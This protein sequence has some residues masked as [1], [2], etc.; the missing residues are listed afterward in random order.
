VK[1]LLRTCLHLQ[2]E[3]LRVEQTH[4]TR[5]VTVQ[6][7]PTLAQE[8]PEIYISTREVD[9]KVRQS[10]NLEELVKEL[11]SSIN[12]TLEN[13]KE[14][15]V[16]KSLRDFFWKIGVDPT[17]VRPTSEALVRRI[18]GGSSFP[19]INNVVDAGNLASA[20]TLIP[21]GLYDLDKIVGEPVLRFARQGEEFIDFTG[22]IIKLEPR[23]IV[24]SDDVGIIH[25]FPY[26]D[27][28]RT[29]IGWSTK[30]VLIVAYGVEGIPKELVEHAADKVIRY[31]RLL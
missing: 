18:L 26:R 11:R 20:E 12:Y 2:N 17:R 21:I 22:R 23:S 29:M 6:I 7:E 4:E 15:R 9:V 8:F 3:S 5:M 14:N 28:L 16:V 31:L 1:D 30:R 25:V 19:L 27:S 24:L 10:R 13:L